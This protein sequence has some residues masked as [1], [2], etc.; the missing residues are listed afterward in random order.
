MAFAAFLAVEIFRGVVFSQRL[1]PKY[2]KLYLTLWAL[3]GITAL[4]ILLVGEDWSCEFGDMIECPHKI[5]F[6][7]SYFGCY[8]DVSKYPKLPTYTFIYEAMVF[9]AICVSCFTVALVKMQTRLMRGRSKDRASR[10]LLVVSG[11]TIFL[12]IVP[13]SYRLLEAE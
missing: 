3:M 13:F 9:S 12:L 11:M 10:R 2:E 6:S 7:T 5:I 1:T 8:V 4:T